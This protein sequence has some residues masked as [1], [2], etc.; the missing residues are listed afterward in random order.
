VPSNIALGACLETTVVVCAKNEEERIEACLSSLSGQGAFEVIVVDGKSTDQ[1]RALANRAGARVVKGSGEGL[2]KDRQIGFEA[3]NSDYVCFIDA[4][5]I[6]GP[7]QLQEMMSS[8]HKLGFDIGQTCLRIPHTSFWC[9]GEDESLSMFH[10]LPGERSMI[11]VAPAVFKKEV[12]SEFPF[13]HFITATIDDTDLIYRVS[14]SGK[15]RIGILESTVQQNHFGNLRDYVSKF[16]WYG[17]GDGEFM[18]KHPKRAFSMVF[19]LSIR[20]PVVYALKCL[21]RGKLAG[22]VFC[23]LQGVLRLVAALM[24]FASMKVSYTREVLE[25]T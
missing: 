5:H 6:L 7:G 23:G 21:L 15:F 12:L 11:G 20:Y 1:T 25:K 18:I 8:M 14:K 2:T 13:D 9:R 17:K 19:H 16:R 3:S 22:A 24:R 10:N 4:D